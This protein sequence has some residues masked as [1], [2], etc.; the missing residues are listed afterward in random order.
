LRPAAVPAAVLMLLLWVVT[1]ALAASP[2]LHGL[3]HPDAQNG[4]HH[5][6]VT[7]LQQQSL[8]SVAPVVVLPLEPP[9]GLEVVLRPESRLLVSHDCP[10]LPGRAPPF[11]FPSTVAVG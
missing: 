11:L 10:L 4:D 5:C 6:A 2:Q 7:V 8:L 9:Q 3:L 1:A